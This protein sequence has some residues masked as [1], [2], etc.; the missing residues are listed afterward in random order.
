[1]PYVFDYQKFQLAVMFL[2]HYIS[3]FLHIIYFDHFAN[4]ILLFFKGE[5][6]DLKYFYGF[7]CRYITFAL[8]FLFENMY[9][10]A[11][12]LLVSEHLLLKF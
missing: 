7:A 2:L 3:L 1:M 4:A 10:T 9:L 12:C 5:I 11:F 8:A 6:R